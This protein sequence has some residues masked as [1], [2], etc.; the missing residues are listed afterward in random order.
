MYLGPDA[1]TN[2]PIGT[3]AAWVPPESVVTTGQIETRVGDPLNVEEIVAALRTERG[4]DVRVV[5]LAG[6]SDLADHMGALCRT[7]RVL[8]SCARVFSLY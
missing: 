7:S 5:P 3:Y 4:E 6:R 2:F 8:L 1:P